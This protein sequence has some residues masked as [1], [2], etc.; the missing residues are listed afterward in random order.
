MEY[1]GGLPAND[2][3]HLWL[4]EVIFPQMQPDLC[5]KAF[6][7][8]AF[9]PQNKVYL[10]EGV[11]SRR[12][13]LGKFFGQAN[14]NQEQTWWRAETEWH[15]L[16]ALRSRGFSS[17]H[18]YIPRPLGLKK[19]LGQ[20][21]FEEYCR[22]ES[23]SEII[24]TSIRHQDA[25]LLF[26]RLSLL[27]W[28]LAKL[29]NRNTHRE[30]VNFFSVFNYFDK[31]ISRLLRRKRMTTEENN[32][33]LWL[34]QHWAQDAA[35][36]ADIQ[37]LTH[38]DATPS[39]FLFT[40]HRR[41]IGIDLERMDYRD[42][43]YDVGMVAGELKHHFMLMTGESQHVE[44]FIGNFLWEYACHFPDREQTFQ[45]IVHRQPFYMGLTLLRIARNSWLDWHYA[46]RLVRE[47]LTVLRRNP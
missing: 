17:R 18:L 15:Y 36:W 45:A 34:R 43:A 35:M 21:L 31:V 42:R 46:R 19:S 26:S 3:L 22:G 9:S 7:V 33:I 41:I 38:G 28:F 8:Y 27:A 20:A 24:R 29:H 11:S 44:P 13:V 2:P 25:D 6:Q 16:Q 37:V 12:K 39:N 47:A 23:L 4:Q 1:L 40:S 14:K 32:E 10:Y 5:E 30:T